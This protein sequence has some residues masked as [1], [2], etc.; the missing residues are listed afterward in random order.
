MLDQHRQQR[1]QLEGRV[2]LEVVARQVRLTALLAV[3]E[4]H[5]VLD[6]QAH[7]LNRQG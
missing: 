1:G 5:H 2:K 3:Y 7:F 4:D 6:N